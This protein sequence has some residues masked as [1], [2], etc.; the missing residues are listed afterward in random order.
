MVWTTV[1]DVAAQ[2]LRQALGGRAEV[3]L[4]PNGIDIHAWQSRDVAEAKP[5]DAHELTVV[6]VSRLAPRKRIRA[7]VEIL[8][9][10][11]LRMPAGVRLRAIIVGD[12]PERAK[13]E[14]TIR[15]HQ[16]GWVE[17]RGWQTH[18][19]IRDI[20]SAAD[21]F[22]APARLES[23]GIAALEA[24]TFGLP[25]VA[26]ADSGTAQFI[27]DGQEGFLATDDSGIEQ[28]LLTLANRPDQRAAIARHN[29][30]VTPE[31]SWP[32][33]VDQAVGYYQEAIRLRESSR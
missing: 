3:R 31:F 5:A 19:Q 18:S 7:L 2:P 17:C 15:R 30:T 26:M 24:R 6:A 21:V 22:V 14:R 11:S 16:M 28:A 13:I 1:S 8:R 9:R 23:F 25:V 33:I 27:R 10:T 20:Y 32:H 12:G 29:R 4:L